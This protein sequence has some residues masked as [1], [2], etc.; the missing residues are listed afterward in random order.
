M[1]IIRVIE[2]I[3]QLWR[4]FKEYVC[5]MIFEKEYRC[6]IQKFKREYVYTYT[7]LDIQVAN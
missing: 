1:S 3:K 5:G 7:S 2:L 4:I 6:M